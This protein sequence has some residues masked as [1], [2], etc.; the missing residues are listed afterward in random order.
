MRCEMQLNAAFG[1]SLFHTK[2]P[3]R[4][5]DAAWTRALTIA[6]TLEDVEYQLRALWGLWSY[7]Y[8]SGEYR[9]VGR[10]IKLDL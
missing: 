3:V 6:E 1:L 7:R 10:Q 9:A 4:E 2:G 8:A 5:T